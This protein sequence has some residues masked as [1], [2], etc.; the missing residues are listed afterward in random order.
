VTDL[1]FRSD[2]RVDLIDSMGDDR[3]LLAAMLVSTTG[4]QSLEMLGEDRLAT[5]PGAARGRLNFLMKNRHGTPFEHAAMTFY[6]EAPIAVFREW[7]RHRIGQSYNEQSGRYR[8]LPPTFY[9]PPPERPLV[10][11]G[12]PGAYTFVPGTPEQYRELV[13][14]LTE[15]FKNQYAAYRS[16]LA[17]GIAKEVARGV[18]GVYLY[19]SMYVT[20]NPRSAMAFLSLRQAH[21]EHEAAFPS[22]PMWEINRCADQVEASFE[23]LFPITHDV[24][25]ANGRVSP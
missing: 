8:E 25:V 18:L 19:S 6:V 9:I 22:K 2:M 14:T 11:V 5:N 3:S 16:L 7:H 24:Y 17:S 12:K 20:L 23:R 10:Q 13:D 1:T 15:T 4:G 21:D